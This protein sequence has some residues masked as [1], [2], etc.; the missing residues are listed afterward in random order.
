MPLIYV[1]FIATNELFGCQFEGRRKNGKNDGHRPFKFPSNFLAKSIFKS[2]M[3]KVLGLNEVMSMLYVSL[4]EDY[5]LYNEQF[6]RQTTLH[7]G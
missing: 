6:G 3:F 5:K 1:D 4:F 7:F 2:D